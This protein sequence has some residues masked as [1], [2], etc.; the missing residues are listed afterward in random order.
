MVRYPLHPLRSKKLS[1]K[2]VEKT[3]KVAIFSKKNDT[4]SR[5]VASLIEKRGAEVIWFELDALERGIPHSLHN[6]YYTYKNVSMD[7]IDGFWMRY[8]QSPIAPWIKKDNE[9]YLHDDWY[10]IYMQKREREAYVLSWLVGLA[11]EGKNIINAPVAGHV[12]QLKPHQIHQF[13]AHGLPTPRTLITNDPN[14][15]RK[16]RKT[17]GEVIFKPTTGGSYC[18]LLTD[19][20]AEELDLIGNSP[21]IFQERIR[22]EDVRVMVLDGEVLSSVVVGVEKDTLDFRTDDNYSSGKITYREHPLPPQALE[23]CTKAAELCQ[24][25]FTG[26]DLKA[27][28]DGSYHILE[29]NSSPI[30]LDVER[31]MG[32]L[33]SERLVDALLAPPQQ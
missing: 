9:I 3:L 13:H 8:V 17:V 16:F 28:P 2:K 20:T 29:C 6:N 24:L 5:H 26:V 22:G 19:E 4:Q 25:R 33:I 21:V 11:S 18:D 23:L 31:K 10:V 1:S 27:G 32:H 7:D 30:Y 14:H 12:S 15:V